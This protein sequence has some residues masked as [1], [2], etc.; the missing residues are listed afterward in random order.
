MPARVKSVEE[1]EIF[2][3]RRSAVGVGVEG[4]EAHAKVSEAGLFELLRGESAIVI[5]VGL[6]EQLLHATSVVR[7]RESRR[8]A[9]CEKSGHEGRGGCSASAPAH[10]RTW[11]GLRA[12]IRTGSA[13]ATS[14]AMRIAVVTPTTTIRTPRRGSS[15]VSPRSRSAREFPKVVRV[16]TFTTSLCVNDMTDLGCV[17]KNCDCA[18]EYFSMAN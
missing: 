16:F 15:P 14:S 5:G 12:G 17:K 11:L 7:A 3:H 1:S 9:E 8:A 4:F 10:G 6:P 18:F 2:A 13:F